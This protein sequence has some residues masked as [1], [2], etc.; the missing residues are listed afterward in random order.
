MNRICLLLVAQILA[1]AIP[2]GALGQEPGWFDNEGQRAPNSESQKSKSGFGGL[3]VITTDQ[4]WEEKW[5]T[6][7]ETTPELNT[8]STVRVGERIT[9]LI[10][11]INPLRD[12]DSQ[13]HVRC[14]IRVTRPDGTL[15]ADEKNM[16]CFKRV[17][18]DE[19]IRNV[20]LAAPYI[21]WMGEPGDPLGEW[22]TQVL[23]TDINR[24]VTLDLKIRFTLEADGSE[25]P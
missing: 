6:P 8:T 21:G 23:L 4:D 20:H 25:S 2:N 7:P 1:L 19:H 24:G 13:A 18:L 9:T 5:S 14:D 12:E 17:V 22:V 16:E 11:L 10:F 15:S 3:L